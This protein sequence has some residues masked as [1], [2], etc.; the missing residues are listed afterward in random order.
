MAYLSI[1]E[2]Y[3]YLF[4][5]LARLSHE[6]GIIDDHNVYQEANAETRAILY[7]VIAENLHDGSC[8]EGREHFA[9]FLQQLKAGKHGLI[10]AEHYSNMDLPLLCYLLE[11]D[12]GDFGK[13]IAARIVAI[14]GKKLN[15]EN[16]MI[17][18]WAEGFSRIVIYPSR[19][20]ASVTDPEELARG[21][22]INLAAT[23]ALSTVRRNGQ[24]VLVFPSGTRYRPGK[25]ETKHGVRETDSYLRIFDIMILVSI[26]GSILRICEDEP[27]NMLA[28]LVVPD[29][30]VMAASPVMYCKQ[31]REEVNAS[32]ASSSSEAI[33]L[34]Q[35]HVDRIMELL[36]LQHEQYEK[37]RLSKAPPLLI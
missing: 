20:L 15:E 7:K 1:R 31:F 6:A 14:S 33:D 2:R 34:K 17:K 18:A 29:T 22:K 30:V 32:L 8:L 16:P 27:D 35:K 26:N 19:S 37:I 13:E 23:R 4:S 11:Q 9:E 28:D 21:R 12:K 5:D 36:A 10:L 24:S 3:S 25:P